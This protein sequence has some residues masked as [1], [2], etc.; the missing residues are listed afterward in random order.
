MNYRMHQS[1]TV[2]EIGVG[3]YGLGGAYGPP[4]VARYV[5]TLRR[6]HELGVTFFDTAHT[7]GDA[8]RILG[9]V[10]RPFRD[11][12]TISTKIAV[13]NGARPSLG[14]DDIRTS[15]EES[16][17]RLEIDH[18]DLYQVHFDDPKTPVEE[19]IETLEALKAAGKIGHYG[20]GHLSPKRAERFLIEGNVF[21]V[22]M[23]LSPMAR[24]SL[25]TLLPLCRRY[26]AAA[27]AF[28]VTGRGLLTGRYQ[29]D[30]RPDFAPGDIRNLD[31]L[32]QRERFV[33]GIRVAEKLREI[34][35]RHGKSPV[36]VAIAWVLAQPR[37]L[38]ALTG[39]SSTAHLEE[40][41]AAGDW[42][43]PPSTLTELGD[44]LTEEEA[45]LAEAQA[46]SVRQIL[47][48]HLPSEVESAF[49]DLVYAMETAILL[50]WIDEATVLPLFQ[51]L[52][53][54]R[55][56]LDDDASAALGQVQRRL[57]ALISESLE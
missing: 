35:E 11:E 44:F 36:Q 50:D 6:A 19:V 32:F 4:D 34:G 53:S 28:S 37:I 7:Y 2:S 40:N 9:E 21:S 24:I 18:I 33:S 54:L 39:P 41:L 23:E 27:I 15:C 51:D 46:M 30:R 31:P 17:R 5:Q 14:R 52:F 10:V 16:L 29:A 42:S 56:A 45:R 43:V 12:V 13:P 48:S 8:E 25:R 55:E 22:M 26:D 47:I 3:C 38:V 20:I 1:L 57:R 49:T